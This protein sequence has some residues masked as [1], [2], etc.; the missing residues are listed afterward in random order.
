MHAQKDNPELIEAQ[1]NNY[2]FL[3]RV[4]FTQS[5]NKKRIVIAGSH[6]KTTIINDY[7]CF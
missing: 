7:A 2:L 6:G 5:I 4:Y 1:K 3:S